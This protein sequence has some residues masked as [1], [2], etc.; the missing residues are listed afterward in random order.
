MITIRDSIL[1]FAS[2]TIK[3]GNH[4][5]I[6]LL[7]SVSYLFEL[8]VFFWGTALG[9]FALLSAARYMWLG[10]VDT[11]VGRKFVGFFG[12]RAAEIDRLLGLELW[13][14][15]V[16]LTISALKTCL[17]IALCCRLTSL[18]KYLYIHRDPIYRFIIW[19]LLCTGATAFIIDQHLHSGWPVALLTGLAVCLP[20][21]Q[22]CFKITIELLPELKAAAVWS[23][24]SGSS[25]P[26][27]PK[28]TPARKNSQVEI[29][30]FNLKKRSFGQGRLSRLYPAQHRAPKGPVSGYAAAILKSR[31]PDSIRLVYPAEARIH[32]G[33]IERFYEGH[34]FSVHGFVQITGMVHLPDPDFK[35][36]EILVFVFGSDGE[37]L[38]KTKPDR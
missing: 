29:H 4:L 27:G 13:D 22:E 5:T 23:L 2:Q 24:A 36:G 31:G 37:L 18:D 11:H 17:A 21:F 1:K 20:L 28:E 8:G 19:G 26:V 34:R 30:N 16:D 3:T 12:S 33:E 25:E 6:W 32:N 15:S 7:K 14:L 38:L 10:Y 35:A 9:C